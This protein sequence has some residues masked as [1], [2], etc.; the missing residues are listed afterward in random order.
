M[1]LD[2]EHETD[3]ESMTDTDTKLEIPDKMSDWEQDKLNNYGH[4]LDARGG[5]WNEAD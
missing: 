2:L 3:M 1:E 5:D 4:E